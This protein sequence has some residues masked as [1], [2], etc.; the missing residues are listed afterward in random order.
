MKTNATNTSTNNVQLSSTTPM[1]TSPINITEE[2]ENILLRMI[3]R[4]SQEESHALTNV[5]NV[6]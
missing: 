4:I 5:G 6:A 3:Y 2:L 1:M